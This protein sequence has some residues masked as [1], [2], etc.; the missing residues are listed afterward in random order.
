[1]LQEGQRKTCLH[2]VHSEAKILFLANNSCD[3]EIINLPVPHST[4]LVNILL[5]STTFLSSKVRVIYKE[6]YFQGHNS[7]NYVTFKNQ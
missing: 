1:M 4:H 7:W 2:L 6:F 5:D 3:N